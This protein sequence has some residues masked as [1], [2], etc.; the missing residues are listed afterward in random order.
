[1]C[2]VKLPPVPKKSSRMLMPVE[3]KLRIGFDGSY[4]GRK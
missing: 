3:P 4:A 1:M 2:G